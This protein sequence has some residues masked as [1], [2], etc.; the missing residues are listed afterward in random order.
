MK[1]F[2]H[3]KGTSL[4]QSTHF[5]PSSIKIGFGVYAADGGKNKQRKGKPQIMKKRT[6]V[7]D[8]TPT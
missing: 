8:F 7:L 6:E 5:E 3:T 2:K 1:K 4:H